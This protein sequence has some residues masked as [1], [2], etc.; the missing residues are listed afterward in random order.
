MAKKRKARGPLKSSKRR[1]KGKVSARRQSV[2]A[3]KAK[4]SQSTAK[5]GKRKSGRS[6]RL[7]A[8]GGGNATAAGVTFQASVG[9]VFAVQM[10]TESF[11]EAQLGLPPFKVKSVR[12]ESD[13]PLDD[14]VVETDQAGWLL[15][16]AK[17]KLGLSASLTSEFGKAV[18]QI[19]RQWHAGAKGGGKRGWDRPLVPDRDR[20]IIAVGPGTSQ[21]VTSDLAKALSSLRATATAPLPARQRAVLKTLSGALKRA[22]KAVTSK[23][24]S[25]AEIS[26]ILPFITVLRFDMAG[27]D[28][29]AAAA[30]LRLLTSSAQSANGA[31]TAVERECQNLMERRHGADAAAFRRSIAHAGI[32]LKAAPSYQ[33]DVETLREYSK[34]TASELAAF[35]VIIVDGKPVSIK[36]AATDAVVRAAKAGSLLIIGEPGSG[37]SAVVS[38]AAAAL[39]ASNADVI[40][41]AV[42]DLPV[43]TPDGLRGQ[44]GLTHRLPDILENWPGTKPA[45]LFVDALDATRGGK[46]EAVFRTL[47]KEV[48]ALP[49]KRWRVVA[50]IRSFDLKLG[51][52]FRDLFC[53]APADESFKDNAFPSV[54]HINVPIWSQAEFDDLLS[55]AKSLAIAITQGGLKLR[56]L[57]A[58]PFN[59]RLLAELLATGVSA[60]AF[61]GVKSQVE[62]LAIYW[63]RRVTP[64]GNGAD[65]CLSAA[66]E[67]MVTTH[68]LQAERLPIAA[69]A[70]AALDGF[71]KA[72][73]LL[74]VFGD[75][76]VRFRHHILF[77][78]AA[79]RLFINPLD[80][81]AIQTRLLAQPGLAL[82][83]A[84]A[85]A[86]ALHDVWLNFGPE[87]EAFWNAIVAL[88]GQ[89]PSDPVAR[90]VAARMAS[91]LPAQAGDAS[92][93]V[94]LLT[95]ASHEAQAA[96]ALEHVVGALVVGIEDGILTNFAPW[97]RFAA[98]ASARIER[99]AW[100]LR[101]LL[102]KIVGTVTDG[103]Q[104][105]QLGVAARAVFKFAIGDASGSR[106]VIAAIDL[107]GET[108]ET[109]IEASRALLSQILA[110]ERFEQH[111][112][113]D[114]P[115]LARAA[116][117][118]S[119]HDPDFVVQ[120]YRTTFTER[121][122]DTSATSM[123]NS[124]ILPLTSNKKQDYDHARW[125]LSQYVPKFF[126]TNSEFGVRVLVTALEGAVASEHKTDEK[127]V[128]VVVAGKSVELLDDGSHVWAHDPDDRHAHADNAAGMLKAF[129]TRLLTS[130]ANDAI[131]LATLAIDRNRLAVLWSRMFLAAARRPDAL[132]ALM[133]PYASALP[134]LKSIDTRKD[135]I[136]A[137]A[138]IYPTLSANERHQFEQ[139]AGTV[140]FE[141]YENPERTK[142]RF[143]GTLFQAIGDKNLATADAKKLL[144][145]VKTQS[146]PTGNNRMFTIHT[147]S[148]TLDPYWWLRDKRVDVDSDANA[149]LLRLAEVVQYRP[150]PDGAQTQT[151]SEAARAIGELAAALQNL[152]D[153]SPSSLVV[154]HA[155]SQLLHGCVALA[156][157][158]TDL[159]RAPAIVRA[160]ADLLE[161]RLSAGAAGSSS[162]HHDQLRA[163]A[164]EAALMLC[165][166]NQEAAARLVP[167]IEPLLN[168]NS[169]RVR[170]E[171]A[172]EIGRL[173]HVD[174][175]AMWRFAEHFASNES[176]FVV[177]RRFAAFITRALHSEPARVEALIAKLIPRARNETDAQ[178]DRII[179]AVG[180]QIAILWLRYERAESRELLDSWLSDLAAHEPELSSASAT[181]RDTVILGYDTGKKEDVRLRRNALRLAK[182][183][184][185]ACAVVLQRYV[186]LDP[187]ARTDEDH[188]AAR[189]AARLLDNVGNQLYFSSGAFK[190]NA[191]E[192]PTGLVTVAAKKAFLDETADILRRIGDVATPH[193]IHHLIDLLASLRAADPVRVFDLA[194]HALLNGG[195]THGYHFESLGA[196]RFVEIVGIFLADHREILSDQARRE[197]LIAC[198]D[199]FVEA[200]WPKARRLL[201]RLPEL[202]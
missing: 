60:A 198:L 164:A 96:K 148:G 144:S 68:T 95:S 162:E 158:T 22:W 36:R 97:C 140:T 103:S 139:T 83:L 10:L 121:V 1:L 107:V 199:A 101:T 112:H 84:P 59:T 61:D 196:D 137:V 132:G 161:P 130:P 179:E 12:F 33:A 173:W 54:R 91:V 39:R 94:G 77:D 76:Y 93:L 23:L 87:H 110:G 138:A 154:E 201:Y 25:D 44:I 6:A 14:I 66:L 40:Q 7:H 24:P 16:Q 174:R 35:E 26:R 29:A 64:L 127:P 98:D 191:Q 116:K 123:G 2:A 28:R 176:S 47:I 34:R 73:V 45:Y 46:G 86:Y 13:A 167:Q 9:A 32:I 166:A 37:K 184:V 109:D 118:I 100:A 170:A 82:M 49:G 74:P 65:V 186:A 195:R 57:A 124:Q 146:M 171:V 187:E 5:D 153:P 104:R 178:G 114:I 120:I 194:A 48:M 4:K 129:M 197:T 163:L 105:A 183:L 122:N 165:A 8:R 113:E 111:A 143:L 79:S 159:K 155:E 67:Q 52:H 182:E 168:D 11:D 128:S 18:E 43:E 78:Y 115:A 172:D 149:A 88:A 160:I 53:G 189:A 99:V 119:E 135:A 141:E 63:S 42:D 108:Y 38:A 150:T 51:E 31:F 147:S 20:L 27:P 70:P 188:N 157:R 117:R 55:K 41:F 90:S 190:A 180:N 134:F 3:A 200:G 15:I 131:N 202:L 56:D 81:G 192:K 145:D 193:T 30:R 142:Q 152:A 72:N 62:L 92:G 19:V 21:T 71:F 102:W 151:V 69:K 181:L 177:L 185:E 89:T 169:E 85:L 125:Q 17:T 106:L 75:R 136:D 50:S 126:E 156:R 80:I 58:V 175:A 133:W